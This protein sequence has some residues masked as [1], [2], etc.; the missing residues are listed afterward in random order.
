[1]NKNLRFETVSPSFVAIAFFACAAVACTTQEA[2]KTDGGAGSS[3]SAG[4]AGSGGGSG[5]SGG[6]VATPA[7]GS[8]FAPLAGTLCLPPDRMIT[9]F[10]FDPDAGNTNQ[11]RFGTYGTTFSGGLS[12][13]SNTP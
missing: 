9:D 8:G 2:K 6:S 7:C 3:G 10:T 5:G 1:M 11:Q 4:H 13:Y 12:A